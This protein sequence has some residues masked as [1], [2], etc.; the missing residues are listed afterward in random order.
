[1][2]GLLDFFFGKKKDKPFDNI[3][4][5]VF[6]RKYEYFKSLLFN[7][8]KALALIN[9]LEDLILEHKPFDY[10]EVVSQSEQLIS[11]VYDI[12]EDI[13]AISG[14]KYPGL[15][16][17][18][19]KIGISILREF[20]RQRKL[21][22][23][24][25][26]ISLA[27]LSRE[28]FDQVGSKAANLGEIFNRVH[29]PTPR[30]F[31]I[32][33]FACHQFLK[34]TK[35]DEAIKA[36]LKGLDIS[37]TQALSQV[38]SEI[39]ATVMNT[40]LP[41]LLDNSIIQEVAELEKEFG[42]DIRLAV[43]S[44]ATGEDSESSFAGQHSTLLNVTPKNMISAYKE[45]VAS[46][47]N[48]RAVFYRRSK[49]YR[50][51]DVLMSVLCLIMVDPVSSGVLYS[52]SPTN[53]NDDDLYISANWGLGVSV[54]DGSMPTDFWRYSR[55]EGRIVT[56]EV[57]PKKQM[58]IMDKIQGVIQ[59]SVQED[60]Q[61]R[62]CLN[63]DQLATLIDYGLK[64]EKHFGW[65]LDMEWAVDKK[66]TVFVLQARPL[67]R[68][69]PDAN[70]SEELGPQ[71]TAGHAVILEGGMT[72]CSGTASG[73]AYHVESEHNLAGIPQGAILIAPQTSPRF[74]SV[75]SR[76]AGIITDVGSVTGHMSSVAREFRIPT[77]VATSNAT[78]RIPNYQVITL[79]ATG[80][81]V[82][83]GMVQ[84]ILKETRPVNLMKDSPVWKLVQKTLKKIIP[85][86]LIDPKKSNF[87]PAGCFTLHDVVRF[88]HEMAMREM[89]NLSRDVRRGHYRATPLKTDPDLNIN[90]LDLGGGLT[91]EDQAAE[92]SMDHVLSIPFR[93]LLRGMF[94]KN[95][96]WTSPDELNM[97]D[98]ASIVMENVLEQ[99]RQKPGL[100]GPNYAIISGEY[101]NF[102]A[103]LG[104]HFATV[105]AYCSEFVNDNYITFSFKGGAADV[106]RRTRRAA[107]I[108]AILKKLGF[109]VE[110]K[111]DLVRA[112]MKKYD[113]VRLEDKI[114]HIGRLLGSVR[115]LDMVL[116]EDGH[117]SWY[118]DQ[119]M[120]GNYT[121]A[122]LDPGQS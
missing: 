61:D 93:A 104:Y 121:F 40:D 95:V 19:E 81:R 46:T 49:G 14:G 110:Q 32:T 65:P 119:F 107:L 9:D 122:R 8:N 117:I 113:Q 92:V 108:A 101:L 115:L 109:R 39:K 114:D 76:I 64:L 55:A 42:P 24:H 102:S 38:C 33:A 35:L 105:D 27:G 2:S 112:E 116:T 11:T 16:K 57:Q 28:S 94:H 4:D 88:S 96:H 85:L 100:D 44:S 22:K 1:M 83:Q 82:Y 99:P 73:P 56:R 50:D 75:M 72:A 68:V 69:L 71:D 30:G 67:Q 118:A 70:D 36:K 12:S 20:V 21:D 6:K 5:A 111:G 52:V 89:F 106:G 66:G 3:E 60:L 74:V 43:R 103:R 41:E 13:N 17:A 23:T 53:K 84:S 7:N 97:M 18:T 62:P 26:T 87:C 63:P 34:Q 79:D 59:A 54:V 120:K 47:F 91:V 78:E 15:F 58:L 90:I 80:K 25:W 51:V 48:P 10:N 77:L 45:V 37:D 31:G 29:L 86:N 98:F